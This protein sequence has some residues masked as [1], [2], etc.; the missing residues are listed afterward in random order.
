VRLWFSPFVHILISIQGSGIRTKLPSFQTLAVAEAVLR[1][2]VMKEPCLFMR[3][4]CCSVFKM[5]SVSYLC[6]NVQLSTGVSSKQKVVPPPLPIPHHVMNATP[7]SPSYASP[8]K[9]A[10]KRAV[11]EG[12]V[13]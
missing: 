13:M 7:S 8:K 9:S 2:M 12:T 11:N 6:A 1:I 10:Q 5:Y 3:T 4:M